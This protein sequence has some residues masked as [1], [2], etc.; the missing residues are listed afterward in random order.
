MQAVVRLGWATF[1][2][3]AG[4]GASWKAEA[5]AEDGSTVLATHVVSLSGAAAAVKLSL[6]VPSPRAGAGGALDLGA[7]SGLDLVAGM[8]HFDWVMPDSDGFARVMESTVG[9]LGEF[10]PAQPAS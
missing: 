4:S 9:F 5:L 1:K 8:D 10:L 2:L 7:A 6:G 3:A